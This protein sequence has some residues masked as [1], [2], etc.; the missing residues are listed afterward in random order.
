MSGERR[1]RSDWRLQRTGGIALI[2][3]TIGLAAT[4]EN[5]SETLVGTMLGFGVLLLG[6]TL[7][8]SLPFGRRDE[9]EDTKP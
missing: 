8:K 5:V 2:A 1:A 6:L 7:P 4:R 9:T 3:T